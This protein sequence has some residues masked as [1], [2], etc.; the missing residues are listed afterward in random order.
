LTANVGCETVSMHS[1]TATRT[2]RLTP[3]VVRYG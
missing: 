1:Q 3:K 2:C